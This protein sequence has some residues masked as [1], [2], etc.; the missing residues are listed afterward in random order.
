MDHLLAFRTDDATVGEIPRDTRGRILDVQGNRC[1]SCRIKLC[2]PH[3]DHIVPR[4]VGGPHDAW[5]VQALCPTCHSVKTQGE[6]RRIQ[7]L[8]RS[9]RCWRCTSQLCASEPG[10]KA[11][12]ARDVEHIEPVPSPPRVVDLRGALLHTIGTTLC[13]DPCGR[14]L[15]I[16]GADC[17]EPLDRDDPFMLRRAAR[18]CIAAGISDES[19]DPSHTLVQL[20]REFR[21]SEDPIRDHVEEWVVA[22]KLGIA[23]S[24]SFGSLRDLVA[25]LLVKVE[26]GTWFGISPRGGSS[27]PHPVRPKLHIEVSGDAIV[28]NPK[29]DDILRRVLV[30]TETPSDK[31]K[32]RDVLGFIARQYIVE[33]SF[34]ER[35]LGKY[36]RET[37]NCVLGFQVDLKGIMFRDVVELR[38]L[39]GPGLMRW[40]EYVAD[41]GYI[42]M[43]Q[44]EIAETLNM[45]VGG[46]NEK[47]NW[48][49]VV[50]LL[51]SIRIIVTGDKIVGINRHPAVL[52]RKLA[53]I[54]ASERA[55]LTEVTQARNGNIS[56]SLRRT[57][58]ERHPE[59]TFRK[60][61]S[62]KR[63]RPDM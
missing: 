7:R 53:L 4:S 29:L 17:P 46:A 51:Q 6:L 57:T 16:H 41:Q 35:M 18:A 24:K 33:G 48:D 8:K 23:D 14:C 60:K 27:P 2:V 22:T 61:E 54:D 1:A 26:N 31:M 30:I 63:R 39:C 25:P 44:T 59:C 49:T 11:C 9:G 40:T 45:F 28:P 55:L 10:S 34:T 38:D 56:T 12:A 21:L 19:L 13:A 32:V 42:D 47:S 62:R 15:Q 50:A 36:I 37:M 52:S 3:F 58:I 5:N 43:T 20:F